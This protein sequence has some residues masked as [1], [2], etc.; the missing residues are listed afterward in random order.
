ALREGMTG[1]EGVLQGGAAGLMILIV[2]PAALTLV[3]VHLVV[4]VRL[5]SLLEAM[6]RAEEGDFLV[7]VPDRGM[8]EVAE[9]GRSFNRLLSR[10][11]D[12]RAEEI[13][14]R[15]SLDAVQAELALQK[16][17]EHRVQ[18]L[19]LL[20]GM[21]RQLTS[22]LSLEELLDRIIALVHEKLQI[23]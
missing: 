9:V 2:L 21:A 6:R 13:D 5:K 7:R 8:D 20:Y 23:P 15:R 19:T 16:T 4:S 14:Q 10:L 3:V 1:G 11:I 22:T 17:L 18:E 12:V